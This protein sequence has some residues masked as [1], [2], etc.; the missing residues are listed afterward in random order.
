MSW[1]NKRKKFKSVSASFPRAIESK[2]VTEIKL[3]KREPEFQPHF[4][5]EMFTSLSSTHIQ[6]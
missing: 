4:A 6:N 3:T 5:D 2:G 1:S